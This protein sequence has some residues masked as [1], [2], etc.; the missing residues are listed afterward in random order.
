MTAKQKR[1]T[2]G[3]TQLGAVLGPRAAAP[4]RKQPAPLVDATPEKQRAT[5]YLPAAL[6]DAMRDAV[7]A[8]SGPPTRLTLNAVAERALRAE[9]ARLEREHRSGRPFP[10]RTATAL[11]PGRRGR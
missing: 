10:P 8:L 5:F 4:S 11:R 7:D 3:D 1:R 6:V 2:I 9:L